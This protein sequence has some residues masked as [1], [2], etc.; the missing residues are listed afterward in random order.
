MF[1]GV[2]AAGDDLPVAVSDAQDLAIADAPKPR[3]N[4]RDQRSEGKSAVFAQLGKFFG[5][6]YTVA[7]V[8]FEG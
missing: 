8:V 1:G 4:F 7:S 5:V 3:R 2:A 6:H